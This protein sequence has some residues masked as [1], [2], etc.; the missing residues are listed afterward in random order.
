MSLFLRMLTYWFMW[1]RSLCCK[2][3]WI[4]TVGKR[5]GIADWCIKVIAKNCY[6]TRLGL[7]SFVRPFFVSLNNWQPS[8]W[9]NR[10][11]QYYWPQ[12]Y[13]TI[14]LISES[15]SS[16]ENSLCHL[17]L[18]NMTRRI[19]TYCKDHRFGLLLSFPWFHRMI[20]NSEAAFYLRDPSQFQELEISF[21]SFSLPS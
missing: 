14:L 12:F 3:K 1:H 5:N 9:P 20:Y 6:A 13:R 21:I 11:L 19:L 17:N 10:S 8:S 4:K 18:F 2:S 15:E 7:I 16:Y